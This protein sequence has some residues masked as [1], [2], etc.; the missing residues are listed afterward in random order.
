MKTK[1]DIKI[2][3]SAIKDYIS[4]EGCGCCEKDEHEE[5]IKILSKLLNVPED[6]FSE[7]RCQYENE[8]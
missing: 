2:I 4:S 7:F 6:Y 3:L 5:H 1:I 8:N